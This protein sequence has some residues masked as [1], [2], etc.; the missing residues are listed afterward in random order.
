MAGTPF[1]CGGDAAGGIWAEAMQ[2]KAACVKARSLKLPIRN[3][4]AA[5]TAFAFAL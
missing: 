5:G 3:R 4:M 1:G 2:C